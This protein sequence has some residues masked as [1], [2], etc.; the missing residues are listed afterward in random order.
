M[1]FHDLL[2]IDSS[3]LGDG[4][5]Q[6]RLEYQMGPFS[7]HS[8]RGK[9]VAWQTGQRS[10]AGL[11][12]NRDWTGQNMCPLEK[13]WCGE[14]GLHS[15]GPTRAPVFAK[16]TETGSTGMTRSTL[17]IAPRSHCSAGPSDERAAHIYMDSVYGSNAE[18]RSSR[19][20]FS[21]YIDLVEIYFWLPNLTT[22]DRFEREQPRMYTIEEYGYQ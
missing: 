7:I 22:S 15:P 1:E 17:A 8:P 19:S 4:K 18:R 5:S 14:S 10:Q 9:G 20:S 21:S 3:A 13:L 16:Q 11:P 2:G 6:G 12:V